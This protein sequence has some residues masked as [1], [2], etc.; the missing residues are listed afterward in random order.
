MTATKVSVRRLDWPDFG[1]PDLPPQEDLPEMEARLALIRA[2]MAA[3]ELSALVIY[4]DREHAANITW[5]TGFDPRFEE[6]LF[7]VTADRAV[8][9]V[10]NECLPYAQISPLVQAGRV[11]VELVPSLSLISQPRKGRRLADALGD[12]VP[13]GAV[14]GA[15]G[16]KY[17][18]ADEV[19]APEAALDLPA[20][21]A[22]PL[23]ALA[24]RVVNATDMF[25]HP[26]HGLRC[27]VD[28]AGIARLEFANHMAAKALTR[29]AF[30]LREGMV[31]FEAFALA[32]LGGLPLG[33]HQTFATG[34]RADQGM[35]GPTGERLRRGV[36]ISFNICHWGSNI[37]RAGWLAAAEA[38]LPEAARDYV[39]AFAGPYVAA[40]SLWCSLMRP[41]VSGGD[42]WDR[43]MTALPFDTFGITLNPGHLI[44]QDEWI[45]SPIAE[46]SDMA[47]QSGMA[48]Q[49]DVIPGHPDYGSTRMEDGYVIADDRLRAELA[50]RFP[51]VAARCAAR[52]EFMRDVIGMDVPETLLPLADTCGIVA[53]YLLDP[54]QV[55]VLR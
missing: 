47:L 7:V 42:V 8:L 34:A 25:M 41:G 4:G 33:C 48:M 45:S 38:D 35:S 27:R 22:D 18:G 55:I 12:L 21:I 16:W 28:A 2:G 13:R 37:C 53:P 52:A 10:G 6:A 9:L 26:V 1:A 24:G 32:G 17:F 15:A 50:A 11:G 40:M 23:R 31:D 29:M 5:A 36:P 19:D 14:I 46:G 39:G 20:F 54:G 44:G 51:A 49:M 30:G 3:R 43:M